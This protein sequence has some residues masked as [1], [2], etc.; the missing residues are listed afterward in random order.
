[1]LVLVLELGP[2]LVLVLAPVLVLVL[3]LALGRTVGLGLG[4]GLGLVLV[5]AVVGVLLLGES[6]VDGFDPGWVGRGD[7]ACTSAPAPHA[8]QKSVTLR[9]APRTMG[10]FMGWCL[11]C[12]GG[13]HRQ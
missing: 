3:A 1:M 9:S 12:R 11:S 8:L 10:C 6:D 4:L 2:A 5:L 7:A 13:H